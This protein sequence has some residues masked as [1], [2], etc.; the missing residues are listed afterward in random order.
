MELDMS[1]MNYNINRLI[2]ST[3]NSCILAKVPRFNNAF[4]PSARL[5]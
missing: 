1:T 5:K 4:Y 2:L 3:N